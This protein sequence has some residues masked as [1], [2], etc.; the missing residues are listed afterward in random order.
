MLLRLAPHMLARYFTAVVDRDWH[1]DISTLVRLLPGRITF[2]DDSEFVVKVEFD[3]RFIS[4]LHNS[5]AASVMCLQL[6]RLRCF[7]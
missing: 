1:P 7:N 6:E 3:S 2:L 4:G 5:N